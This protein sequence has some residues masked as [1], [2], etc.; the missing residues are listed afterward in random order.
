[1]AGR[2]QRFLL[3]KKDLTTYT[4]HGFRGMIFKAIDI[5]LDYSPGNNFECE[6]WDSNPSRFIRFVTNCSIVSFIFFL[7]KTI[8]TMQFHRYME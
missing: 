7:P 4:G 6:G 8:Y 3:G 5:I 2:V 1:M